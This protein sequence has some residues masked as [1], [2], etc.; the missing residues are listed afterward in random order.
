MYAGFYEEGDRCPECS[1]G[2]LF[3]PPVENCTCHISPP[4]SACIN[5]QLQCDKCGHQPEEPEYRDIPVTPSI[6]GLFLVEREYKPKP[7]DKTKIDYRIKG[8]TSASQICEGVYPEGTTRDE[9]ED[10][11]RGTFGGRFEYFGNGKFKYIA[12]TD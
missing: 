2:K 9:V 7:L 10:V 6:A 3:Y 12:Y 5:N 8:Y 1:D 11:V 4:C